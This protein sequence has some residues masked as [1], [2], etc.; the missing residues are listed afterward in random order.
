MAIGALVPIT[1]TLNAT[2]FGLGRL[3]LALIQQ[4]KREQ[5]GTMT[6][7]VQQLLGEIA[8]GVHYA[9]NHAAIRISLLLVTM[10]NLATLGPLIGG[11]AK[12]VELRFGGSA[13]TYGYLQAAFG[14]GAFVGILATSQIR[15]VKN[16]G[17]SL[18]LLAYG[19]GVGTVRLLV[20][21]SR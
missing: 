20:S 15:S 21:S 14:V 10:L 13:L 7:S 12:L 8:E 3:L 9:W 16:P 17:L 18:V 11:V 19:L 1:F 4:P 6:P 2:L 5:K